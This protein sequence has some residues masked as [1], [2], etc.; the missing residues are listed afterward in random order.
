MSLGRLCL[1]ET[2]YLPSFK[3]S[4][5]VLKIFF[6]NRLTANKKASITRDILEIE[7]NAVL[8]I[9]TY[10]LNALQLNELSA[11][12]NTFYQNTSIYID[13]CMCVYGCVGLC[14]AMQGCVWLCMAV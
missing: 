4:S 1:Y 7:A 14:M 6:L 11:L 10:I 2:G 5:S 3:F 8:Y 13:T 12:R 9:H